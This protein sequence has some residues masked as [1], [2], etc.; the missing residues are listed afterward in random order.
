MLLPLEACF[1]VPRGRPPRLAF[2]R[3]A[4]NTRKQMG[5]SEPCIKPPQTPTHRRTG[6]CE[7]E[8]LGAVVACSLPIVQNRADGRL[9]K[10]DCVRGPSSDAAS[11][12]LLHRHWRSAICRIG[13]SPYRAYANCS[14]RSCPL[15]V[16]RI[17]PRTWRISS[18]LEDANGSFGRLL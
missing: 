4:P 10:A 2:G 18:A 9:A 12:I 13:A 15:A 8:A 7:A 16:S 11:H 1:H 17:W 14:H 5:S 3:A 6:G